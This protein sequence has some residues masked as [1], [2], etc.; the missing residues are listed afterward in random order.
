[1]VLIVLMYCS[2]MLHRARRQLLWILQLW[3][4][5]QSSPKK[6]AI[7]IHLILLIM[8]LS[9]FFSWMVLINPSWSQ[10]Q[11]SMLS[12]CITLV[13]NFSESRIN[14]QWF[15]I[16]EHSHLSPCCRGVNIIDSILH[17][18]PPICLYVHSHW[19]WLWVQVKLGFSP[20]KHGFFTDRPQT[21]STHRDRLSAYTQLFSIGGNFCN[22]IYVFVKN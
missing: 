4:K 5:C 2:V 20:S 15:C 8:R 6:A 16:L 3:R 9:L 14:H 11:C 19:K 12:H 18:F 7:L 21:W 13:F 17:V 1:M 22:S 10:V